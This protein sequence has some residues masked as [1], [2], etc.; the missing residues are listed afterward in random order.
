MLYSETMQGSAGSPG[1]AN[2]PCRLCGTAEADSEEHVIPSAIG[3]R[4]VALGVLCT[5]CNGRLGSTVDAAFAKQFEAVRMMLGVEGDRGQS[6]SLR[7]ADVTGREVFLD[8]GMQL[9]A[10][11]NPPVILREDE[12]G[13]E[14]RFDSV[15]QARAFAE[16]VQRKNPG[17]KVEVT[18][19]TETIVFPRKINLPLQIGGPAVVRSAVKSTLSLLAARGV[20]GS[21]EVLARAWS[22]VRGALEESEAGVAVHHAAAPSPWTPASLGTVSHRIAARSNVARGFVEADVRYFGEIG[23]VIRIAC[24]IPDAFSLAYGVDPISGAEATS[25]DWT[26]AVGIP[27]AADSAQI[28]RSVERAFEVVCARAAVFEPVPRIKASLAYTPRLGAR[29]LA[30][31]G[32]FAAV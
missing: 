28:Y 27:F 13:Y 15:E 17:R 21:P 22:Y 11:P 25:D 7:A 19:V 2:A 6:V 9:R 5:P 14:A 24:A 4:L 29:W 23:F 31:G 30:W 10:A 3:G 32:A 20:A 8:P 26:G 18:S 12:D 16:S 1:L